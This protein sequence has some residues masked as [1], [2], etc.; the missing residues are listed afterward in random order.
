MRIKR[1]LFADDTQM[2][3]CYTDIVPKWDL[4]NERPF[5]KL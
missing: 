4:A 2:G 1:R 3:K 5:L